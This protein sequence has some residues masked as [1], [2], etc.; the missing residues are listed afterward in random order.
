MREGAGGVWPPSGD[1]GRKAH[2][3]GLP[4]DPL[5]SSCHPPGNTVRVP[6]SHIPV[7]TVS[8][9]APGVRRLQPHRPH[10]P[11]HLVPVRPQPHHSQV[12]RETT[13]SVQ[14]HHHG[15]SWGP[16][17]GLRLLMTPPVLKETGDSRQGW[18]SGCTHGGFRPSFVGKCH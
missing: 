12:H 17:R 8:P 10:H 16:C 1:R 7:P 15:E 6:E 5:Q 11:R 3:R 4:G 18:G 2:S 13:A 9:S 14:V